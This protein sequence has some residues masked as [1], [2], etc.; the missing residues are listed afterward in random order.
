MNWKNTVLIVKIGRKASKCQ[1]IKNW[2]KE[3]LE[4]KIKNSKTR[5]R[6]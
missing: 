6:K 2:I 3:K 5:N 4:K 1:E